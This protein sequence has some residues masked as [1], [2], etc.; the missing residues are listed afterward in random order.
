[1]KQHLPRI[2]ILAAAAF[3]VLSISLLMVTQ[4]HSDRTDAQ[5]SPPGTL[6]GIV[7]PAPGNQGPPLLTEFGDFQ[8][9]YCAHFAL[10]VMPALREEFINTELINFEYRHYPF[11]GEESVQAAEASECARDQG[12][13]TQYHDS[14]Y[15]GLI[16]GTTARIDSQALQEKARFLGMNLAQFQHCTEA[17][18]HKGRVQQDHAYGR[19][20]RV[21]GTPTLFLNQEKVTWANYQ[22][23]RAQI[24]ES[25]AQ[26]TPS[27]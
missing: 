25:I 6:R 23:L 19:S 8:C 11:L 9:P 20:L 16:T 17:R 12:Q 21:E 1:M 22:D 10:A 7:I 2:M 13:F 15:H 24:Q 14:L 26:T 5:A 18:T 27:P 4:G 3:G